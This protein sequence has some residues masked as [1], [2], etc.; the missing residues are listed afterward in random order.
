MD[1]IQL[2][3]DFSIDFVTEGHKHSRPGWVNVEC[4]WCTGNPGYHLGYELDGNFYYCWRCGWHRVIPTVSKLL[5]VVEAEAKNLLRQYGLRIA[6]RIDGPVPI[7]QK[8]EFILPLNYPLLNHHKMYLERRGFDPERLESIWGLRS[9]SP[10]SMIDN[11]PY[12]NR[13]LIPFFWNYATVSFDTRSISKTASHE[14]RYKA[15]PKDREIIPHKQILY[16]RQDEWR[17]TGICVEGPTDVWRL[18]TAS[19]ATSGIQY[20]DYQLHIMSQTFKRVFVLFDNDPQAIIQA[21]KLVADL[22]FRGVDAMRMGMKMKTDPGDMTQDEAN[23]LVKQL[24]K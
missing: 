21:N 12:K 8:L 3:Q 7:I 2:Y 17:E 13:I 10:L 15:C 5:K 20:T 6:K 9:T 24:I 16:G 14:K 18:G 1:I 4:P 22:K 19:F 23:Y 11:I